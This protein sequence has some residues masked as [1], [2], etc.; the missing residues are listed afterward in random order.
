VNAQP[1]QIPLDSRP[2][3][4]WR[5][6]GG[7]AA[8]LGFGGDYNPEQ[9]PESVWPEDIELMREAG[10]TMAT[11]GVFSWARLEPTPGQFEFGWLDRVLDLLHSGGIAVDLATATASPPAWLAHKHPEMLPMLADGTRLW[12]GGRQAFCPSSPVYRERAL[13]LVERI[14]E[15]YAGHP[16]LALWHVGN[17]FGCHVAR[18]WCD[19]SA[20]AFRT[21]LSERYGN[22]DALNEAWGTAFWSQHYA[23]W[24]EILP[25]RAAPTHANPTQQLDF[26]RFSSDEL[27]ANFCAERDV[28][29]RYTSEV[30]VTTN[31]MVMWNFRAL[32][33]WRWAAE[34][35]VVSNDH[36][37]RAEDPDR[38]IELAFSADL[39]RS[40]ARGRP[41]IQMEHSTSAVNWQPRNLPKRPGEM[42]R[43]SFQLIAHGADAALFFQWRQSRAGAEKFHSALLPHAGT[44]SRVW[45]EVTAL[46][47]DLG[48]AAEVAGSTSSAQVAI[49]LDW[50]AGWACEL[51]SHPSSDVVYLDRM[52]ALYRALWQRGVAVDF[53]HPEADLSGYRLALVPT[54][55][56]VTDSGAQRL[57]DFVQAGGTALVTYF[58]GIVDESDHV[59]LGGYPGA[60]CEL[61][62]VRV[63]EFAPLAA[64]ARVAMDDGT[65]ADL[66]TEDLELAGAEAVIRYVDGPMPGVPAV[67]RHAYGSGRAWYA[68]TRQ[69][70]AGLG[71][72]VDRLLADAGVTP[73]IE[74]TAGVEVARRTGERGS[75][76]FVINHTE[77]EA[78]VPVLGVELISGAAAEGSLVVAGGEVA[79]IRE[80]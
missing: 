53:A 79:V 35:D 54:L 41:W 7:Q 22:L 12:P 49:V 50:Q 43:N 42:R 68:A 1:T 72:L 30:P 65:C 69:D 48:A 23:D 77:S 61:L 76:L 37:L 29:R 2:A 40:L 8:S 60:Y 17:E 75:F 58:S 78:S 14:A 47:H 55:Y 24:A 31:F 39:T 4:P 32:D 80:A 3:L 59:R 73:V 63:Q 45:R 38:H 11:V 36:Y 52:R 15:R 64:G 19:V 46:G 66:W 62:G 13:A 25:P 70:D 28:L 27:L 18:C 6:P 34:V 74:T 67:T 57:V 10:V 26:H 21:W 51:D 16:A 71:L 20:E 56:S 5:R 33:Y 44:H 9:W